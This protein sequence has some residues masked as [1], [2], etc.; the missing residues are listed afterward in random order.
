MVSF[1]Y[2]AMLLG[3]LLGGLLLGI[4]AVP[5]NC[6]TDTLN[7]GIDG[8]VISEQT[9]HTYDWS[10]RLIKVILPLMILFIA[11]AWGITQANKGVD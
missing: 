2:P 10:V 5:I 8:E 4:L 9:R 1:T 7:N 3:I 11:C 6:M